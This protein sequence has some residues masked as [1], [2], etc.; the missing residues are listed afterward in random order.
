VQININRL[1]GKIAENGLSGAKIADVLEI[2]HSTY[3]RKLKKG[4]GG[5]TIAEVQKIA[6]LL[7]L[8]PDECSLIFFKDELAEMQV[9]KKIV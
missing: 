9:G 8:S 5:F 2:D 4:G 3:Y 1:K 7:S 6:N